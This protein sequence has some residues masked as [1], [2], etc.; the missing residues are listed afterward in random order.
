[1]HFGWTKWVVV[2]TGRW[3]VELVCDKV[4]DDAAKG[5]RN[6][7]ICVSGQA[8]FHRL[9]IIVRWKIRRHQIKYKSCSILPRAE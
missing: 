2:L 8:V 9:M 1:M 3:E 5:M 7:D 4:L 6:Q